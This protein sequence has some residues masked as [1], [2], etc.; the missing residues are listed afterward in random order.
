MDNKRLKYTRCERGEI[1]K[2]EV[3][4]KKVPNIAVGGKTPFLGQNS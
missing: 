4:E 2:K 3:N 1:R